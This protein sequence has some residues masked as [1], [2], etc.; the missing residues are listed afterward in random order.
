MLSKNTVK[1]LKTL[2]V[3]KDEDYLSY[4]PMKGKDNY[5]WN[6]I[7]I[8]KIENSDISLFCGKNK[9]D[10]KDIKIVKV[11]NIDI[12]KFEDKEYIKHVLKEINLFLSLSNYEYFP[13]N[14]SVLMSE[15]KNYLYLIINENII[16]INKII[17][18]KIFNYLDDKNLV[19][20]II[21][22]IAFGIYILHSN[23]IIHHD[24]KPSNIYIDEIGGIRLYGFDNSIFKNEKSFGYAL[25]YSPPEILMDK[26]YIDEKVDMWS[27]GIILIE[28]FLKKDGFLYKEDIKNGEQQ[29]YYILEKLYGIKKENYSMNDLNDILNGNNNKN[30]KFKIDQKILDEI[31]DKDAIVLINNLLNFDPKERYTAKQVLESDYLKEFIGIDLLDV[32]PIKFII[33]NDK[34]TNN[35]IEKKNFLR[36]NFKNYRQI[37]IKYFNIINLFF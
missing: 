23:N 16:S 6:V 10:D 4:L 19:K 11:I 36:I 33:N 28:I 15:D 12:N 24:I 7:Q 5:I 27:L 9:L 25:P 14:V 30:I 37:I 20:W 29:L 17:I 2:S 3:N 21:Y 22:Q 1:E 8:K 31:K 34:I 35:K 26:I 32:R 13:K 18:S